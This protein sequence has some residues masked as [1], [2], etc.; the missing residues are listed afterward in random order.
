MGRM[1]RVN[2][3]MSVFEIVLF[4][5]SVRE[6][7]FV[8]GIKY[9]CTQRSKSAGKRRCESAEI[10]ASVQYSFRKSVELKFRL[11]RNLL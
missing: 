7:F 11:I 10:F 2:R 9:V 1:A 3:R 4:K 6:C 8:R 5:Q